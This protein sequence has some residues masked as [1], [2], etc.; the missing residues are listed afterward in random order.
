MA[1]ELMPPRQFGLEQL[2]LYVQLDSDRAYSA[3]SQSA[4]TAGFASGSSIGIQ[5]G[6]CVMI[7]RIGA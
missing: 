7:S 3:E 6:F 1:P 5:A 2:V 4:W